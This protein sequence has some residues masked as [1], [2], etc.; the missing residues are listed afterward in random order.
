MENSPTVQ[1]L[2]LS[3]FTVGA[4]VQSLVRELRSCELRELSRF[5]CFRFFMSLWTVVYQ[6][7]QL[8]GLCSF[9]EASGEKC[10]YLFFQLLEA[11]CIPWLMVPFFHLQSQQCCICLYLSLIIT[12]SLTLT[13]L[14]PSSTFKNFCDYIGHTWIIPSLKPAD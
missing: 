1:W 7:P 6:P 13:L 9:Q 8:T 4:Q 3:A 5:S 2:G 12:P 14:P 11:I 10:V